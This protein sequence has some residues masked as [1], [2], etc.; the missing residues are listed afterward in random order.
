MKFIYTVLLLSCLSSS[1]RAMEADTR[2]RHSSE[3]ACCSLLVTLA[4]SGLVTEGFMQR[5][6]PSVNVTDQYMGEWSLSSA[7]KAEAGFFGVL[8]G[9]ICLEESDHSCL[10]GHCLNCLQGL[11]RRISDKKTI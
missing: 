11:R 1:I 3:L 2:C 4:S 7:Y 6:S 8:C 9:S 10:W 5:Y